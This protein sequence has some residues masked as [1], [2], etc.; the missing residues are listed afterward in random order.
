MG[1]LIYLDWLRV[2][3]TFAVVAI[4]ATAGYVSN[5]LPGQEISW[6]IGNFFESLTRWAVPGFVMISGALLLNDKRELSFQE[7]FKKRTSKVFIPFIGWSFLFY[8][9]GVYA[10]YF[11]TSIIEGI[12][13]FIN[14][15]ITYHFWF[16]YDYRLVFNYAID[17]NISRSCT[18][19]SYSILSHSMDLC[20]IYYKANKLL[21]WNGVYN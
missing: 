16:L 4:H 14:N 3:A 5:L 12:K 11:P 17:K 9:Y 19:T 8:L 21:Y 10:G 1:R 15:G 20:F 7:F 18:K 13:L 2:L 6:H